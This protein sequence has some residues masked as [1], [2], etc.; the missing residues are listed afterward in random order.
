M[1][2]YKPTR[3]LT[4]ILFCTL[5]ILPIAS[6][7]LHAEL[8]DLAAEERVK[9]LSVSEL[10]A[11]LPKETL[12]A[13]TTRIAGPKG[14]VF[15]EVNDC[16][17]QSGDP[18]ADEGRDMPACVQASI[19]VPDGREFGMLITVGTWEKGFV[20]KPTVRQVYWA[21]GQQ[22]HNLKRLSQIPAEIKNGPDEESEQE[23]PETGKQ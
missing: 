18:A 15:W 4:V 14:K 20:G 10:D 23:E 17:Q 22:T 9:K 8:D 6:S 21:E 11:T 3:R 5:S 7:L 2:S 12:V 1:R 16:G 19:F 13:W